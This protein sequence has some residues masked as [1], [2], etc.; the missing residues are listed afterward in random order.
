VG[1]RGLA[2]AFLAT[3]GFLAVSA[4]LHPPLTPDIRGPHLSIGGP[5]EDSQF[6]SK[7]LDGSRGIRIDAVGSVIILASALGLL[8]ILL[9]P[10][11]LGP[12]AGFL[13]ALAIGGNCA[14]AFNHPLLIERLDMEHDQ[15]SQLVATLEQSEGDVLTTGSNSRIPGQPVVDA[16]F[17]DLIRGW[18]Y[19]LYG[20]WLVLLCGGVVLL[21]YQGP[22]RRRIAHLLFWLTAGAALSIVVCLPRLRAELCW[23]QAKLSEMR[24]DYPAARAHL[25]QATVIVP[26]LSKMQRSWLLAGKLDF[27][28]GKVTTQEWYFRAHQLD[29]RERPKA[30]ALMQDMMV[31]G[32]DKETAARSQLAR[33]LTQTGLGAFH[34]AGKV[35]PEDLWRRGQPYFQDPGFYPPRLVAAHDAWQESIDIFPVKRGDTS[36]YLGE[37]TRYNNRF[38]PD[39]TFDCFAPLLERLPDRVLRADVQSTLG[40][41]FFEAGAF[42][43]ARKWYF[44][45]IKSFMLPKIINYRG[46]K[47]LGG[48]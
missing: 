37:A 39:A 34:Q 45:S 10:T 9:K 41:A 8:M 2:I 7:A 29:N 47:G 26:E 1:P 30:K 17:G 27:Y 22:L 35:V 19:L 20:F 18:H 24:G 15:R 5:F 31:N 42:K 12:V 6:W 14:A 40:N 4:W 48:L 25:N 23:I 38:Q 32:A 13:L 33:I 43:Q 16:D 3:A 44:D 11:W 46:Q 28:E 36:L 21:A